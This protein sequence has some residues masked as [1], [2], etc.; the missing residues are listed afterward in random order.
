MSEDGT[1][2]DIVFEG[3]TKAWEPEK[4]EKQPESPVG[5]ITD[6]KPGEVGLQKGGRTVQ[7]IRNRMYLQHLARAWPFVTLPR[8]VLV[9]TG[10]QG[11][12]ERRGKQQMGV[13]VD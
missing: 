13:S 10:M 3:Q 2:G 7:K 5:G 1:T 9:E 4:S 6:A 12:A 8:A 11:M